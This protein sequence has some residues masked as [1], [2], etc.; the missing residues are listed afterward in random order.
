MNNK[1]IC[2]MFF[3]FVIDIKNNCCEGLYNRSIYILYKVV[4]NILN[5]ISIY[6]DDWSHIHRWIIIIIW[7]IQLL[8]FVLKLSIVHSKFIALYVP[9]VCKKKICSL[10]LF[11][12]HSYVLFVPGL[13]EIEQIVYLKFA[14]WSCIFFLFSYF[15]FGCICIK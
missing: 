11:L 9:K 2:V 13:S 10:S 1:Y 8:H 14:K 5:M 15:I 4:G 3:K 12:Y 7:T 6:I